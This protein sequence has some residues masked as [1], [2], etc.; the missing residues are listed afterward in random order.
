V[1]AGGCGGNPLAWKVGGGGGTAWVPKKG[2]KK[3]AVPG[4]YSQKQIH[5]KRGRRNKNFLYGFLREETGVASTEAGGGGGAWGRAVK[6]LAGKNGLTQMK[7]S[8]GGKGRGW[9]N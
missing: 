7:S 2:G 1:K 8:F 4:D 5:L 6:E 9:E 3:R